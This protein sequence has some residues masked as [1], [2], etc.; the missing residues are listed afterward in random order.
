MLSFLFDVLP[1]VSLNSTHW[2]IHTGTLHL[3]PF[4][5]EFISDLTCEAGVNDP[6]TVFH[7]SLQGLY[8]EWDT[9]F[10]L[11]FPHDPALWR[12]H[13]APLDS[14]KSSIASKEK[15]PLP[16]YLSEDDKKV[17]SE[18]LRKGGLAAPTCY[19]KVQVRG[20]RVQDDESA[21]LFSSSPSLFIQHHDSTSPSNFSSP[22][23]A[24]PSFPSSP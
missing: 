15:F 10:G 16:S 20:D 9:F 12:T 6:I 8:Q 3:S 23:C 5:H 19:Y 17:M 4:L 13:V 2:A 14:L 22:L 7:N 21:Y 24:Y 1:H 18:A 11:I